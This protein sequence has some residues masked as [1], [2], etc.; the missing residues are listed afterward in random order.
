MP[1]FTERY[2]AIFT[3]ADGARQEGSGFADPDSRDQ[4][5][6]AP[7]MAETAVRADGELEIPQFYQ[8]PFQ[9]SPAK[10]LLRKGWRG[11]LPSGSL[12]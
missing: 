4:H 5:E 10:Y 8:P 2:L 9:A 1:R 3:R 6:R 12:E 11:G 7:R